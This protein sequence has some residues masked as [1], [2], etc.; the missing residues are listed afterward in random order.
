LWHFSS[1]QHIPPPILLD[2]IIQI[3][4]IVKFFIIQFS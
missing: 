2:L 4:F 3:I 1:I